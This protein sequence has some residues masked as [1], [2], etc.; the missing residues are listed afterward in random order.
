MSKP[1]LPRRFAP[2][3][4]LFVLLAALPLLASASAD[5]YV[6][7]YRW[8]Q[9][10]VFDDEYEQYTHIKS[11]DFDGDGRMDSVALAGRGYQSRA[12]FFFQRPDG[13]KPEPVEYVIPP[14]SYTHYRVGAAV[15][16]LDRDGRQELLIS[17]TMGLV[18]VWVE[19]DRT[20]RTSSHIANDRVAQGPPAVADVDN[21]GHLDVVQGE[22]SRF[23]TQPGELVIRYGDGAGGFPRVHQTPIGAIRYERLETGDMNGD[24]HADLVGMIAPH[25]QAAQFVGIL[26]GNGRGTFSA[27]DFSVSDSPWHRDVVVG[28]MNNDG[29]DDLLAVEFYNL[30]YFQAYEI[31]PGYIY[32]Q[33]A[34]GT[35]PEKPAPIGLVGWSKGHQLADVDGDGV[36]DL[37]SVSD[38]VPALAGVHLQ[39]DGVFQQPR[40]FVMPHASGPPPM[41]GPPRFHRDSQAYGDFDGDGV[42]DI[43]FSGGYGPFVMMAG[44]KQPYATDVRPPGPPRNVAAAGT[45]D[46]LVVRVSFEPPLDDGGSP[47]THYQVE[48]E[49]GG[50]R[51]VF[52]DFDPLRL[53]RPLIGQ[54]NGERYRYRVRA[55]NAAGPGPLSEP[56]PEIQV[57]R[58]PSLTATS[59]PAFEPYEGVANLRF[60]FR[61][62]EPALEGGVTFDVATR[63]G[64]AVAGLDYQA[65]VRTGV[66]I[67]EGETT[68]FLDVPILAD[69]LAEFQEYFDLDVTNVS[70]A[71]HAGQ[72][73]S[74]IIRDPMPLQTPSSVRVL[75]ASVVEGN[76]GLT[77]LRFPIQMLPASPV[78]VAFDIRTQDGTARAGE[79]YLARATRLVIPAGSTS[80]HFD[81]QVI[82]DLVDEP[83][84]TLFVYVDQVVGATLFSPTTQATVVDDD[85]PLD[86]IPEPIGVAAEKGHHDLEFE[87]PTPGS[88]H[89]SGTAL[90]VPSRR[91]VLLG[92]DPTPALPFDGLAAGV[93]WTTVE[94]PANP[95][96][97]AVEV[98][99]LAVVQSST[100]QQ[101][102]LFVGEGATPSAGSTACARS[103]AGRSQVCELVLR[104]EPGD[105][106]STYWVLAQ[107]A[108]ASGAGV[109]QVELEAAAVALVPVNRE[110]VASGP[111]SPSG[112]FIARINWDIP[113]LLP[114]ERRLGYLIA[115]SSPGVMIYHEPFRLHRTGT[116][117]APHVL[118]PGERRAVHLEAADA[119]E[120]LVFDVPGNA[121]SVT[122]TMEGV[123]E[124]SLHVSHD[125]APASPLIVP[126]PPRAQA[127]ASSTLPGANQSVTLSGA[128][129]RKGRWYVTPQNRGT[130]VARVTVR[131][132]VVRQG[133]RPAFRPGH[134]YNPDRPGHGVFLDFAGDQWLMV[135]YTYLQDGTPTWYYTQGPTPAD[136]DAQWAVDLLRVSRN[137]EGTRAVRVGSATLT[138][139]EGPA[140]ASPKIAFGYNLDGDAGWEHLTRLGDDACPVYGGEALDATGHW[141]APADPGYGFSVQILPNT[142]IYAAYIYDS[143]GFP[144]WLIGQKDFD[145]VHDQ[146]TMQQL[147]GFCPT[148]PWVPVQS[149]SV[150]TLV[151]KLGPVSNNEGRPGITSLD[152]YTLFEEPLPNG[153]FST[154]AP[155]YLL[156]ARKGCE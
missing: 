48:A 119:H 64:T 113:S 122:F 135:W 130:D 4:A 80:A 16:D 90:V 40:Y 139:L 81:V 22:S 152:M 75:L 109:D 36:L 107:N 111:A 105:P 97:T 15:A 98:R 106:A 50:I 47:I 23:G 39:R 123:G 49:P 34:D 142:E 5:P 93:A 145:P 86:G 72:R 6:L 132:E 74:A 29:R 131:A 115:E 76:T 60:V 137:R 89:L 2:V 7:E 61:L 38:L 151:R 149:K 58:L 35:L 121:S 71:V 55:F 11:G 124:A 12:I 42:L 32:H 44:R 24:G 19:A 92:Q 63:D 99:V 150:S 69:D 126:A 77:T 140:G 154:G 156:S 146:V 116:V 85:S 62:S 1:R 138:V 8:Q 147:Q 117:D 21:D 141:Y 66:R 133:A 54:V 82:A 101:V 67:P 127:D 134:Y 112:P 148:C 41:F 26:Y 143:P 96:P 45:F 108:A 104:R 129:L 94:A 83:N 9:P 73:A 53:S 59:Q 57:R 33:R 102:S 65:V 78:D 52:F 13:L 37:V 110:L 28:D 103:A 46:E 27:P 10:S 14:F 31:V 125:A 17:S 128:Q 136:D 114:G 120:R 155:V 30:D 79:D 144:R 70:E 68:T 118:A 91:D 88:A 25:A 84:E 87:F 18:V 56:S 51:D 153:A 20:F 100:A 3:H 43:V 95:T